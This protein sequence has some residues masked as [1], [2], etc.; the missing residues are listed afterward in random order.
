MLAI[1]KTELQELYKI[2]LTEYPDILTVKQLRSALGV[3][4]EL[5]YKLIG[6]GHIHA[7]MVGKSYRIPKSRVIKFLYEK[8]KKK[9]ATAV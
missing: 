9:E 7:V 5:A 3:S 4:R 6:D 1:P 2:M 8:Q